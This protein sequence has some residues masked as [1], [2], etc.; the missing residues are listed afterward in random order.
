MLYYGH[1]E[2]DRQGQHRNFEDKEN[3]QDKNAKT[4]DDN[5]PSV[6]KET[7]RM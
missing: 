4:K 7:E 2:H 6:E 3:R 5:D 1:P